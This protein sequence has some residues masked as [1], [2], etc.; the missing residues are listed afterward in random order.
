MSDAMSEVEVQAIETFGS[1]LK[2]LGSDTKAIA[3]LVADESVPEVVRRPLAGA[4]N[5]LFKSL[6]LIDDGIEGLGFMDDAFVLRIAAANAKAAGPLPE[7]LGALAAD[8]DLIREILGDL[9]SRLE[10]FV[11][12]LESG[13]VRGRSVDG[14]VSDA[15]VREELIGEVSGWAS[16]YSPPVFVMDE[17]GLVKLR[18]FL[19]AK[20]P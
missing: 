7:G 11:K 13:V 9:T 15:G 16:R 2:S 3:A 19:A 4:L 1:W 18:S 6:D 10:R 5:Y 8:A 17:Q 14:I 20:L 12:S